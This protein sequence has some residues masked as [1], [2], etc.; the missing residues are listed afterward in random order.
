MLAVLTAGY[1]RLSIAGGLWLG[2]ARRASAADGLSQK[3]AEVGENL[4][5]CSISCGRNVGETKEAMH[6]SWLSPMLN[7]HSRVFQRS[8]ERFA[9]VSQRVVFGGDEHRRG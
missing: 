9:F 1:H 6:K 7:K 8:D 3:P 2:R 5:C 4:I